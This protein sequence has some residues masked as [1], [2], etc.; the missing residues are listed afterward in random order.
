MDIIAYG[1]FGNPLPP[2]VITL[3]MTLRQQQGLTGRE[4]L[5]FGI[6]IRN[7]L[8]IR[9]RCTGNRARVKSSKEPP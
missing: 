9:R 5:A 2:R 6:K 1:S 3:P 7:P 4:Q 8:R